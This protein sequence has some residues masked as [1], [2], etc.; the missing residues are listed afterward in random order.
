MNRYRTIPIQDLLVGHYVVGIDKSWLDT[1]F[2]SHRFLINS[3]QEIDRLRSHGVRMVMIDPD[4]SSLTS[5]AAPKTPFEPFPESPLKEVSI[6]SYK[7]AEMLTSLHKY[8]VVKY[9]TLFDEIRHQMEP[10]KKLDLQPFMNALGEVEKLGREYPDAYLFL[11]HLQSTDDETFIHSVNTM[12][13]ALYLAHFRNAS[14]DEAVLWGLSGLFHDMGKARIPLEILH[15]KEPLTAEE[16]SIIREHP[17]TGEQII[18][19]HTSLPSLV[20]KVAGDHHLRRNGGYPDSQ[21]FETTDAVTRAI[22]IF[23]TF[24]ALTSDR[25]YRP[26]ISPSK[27]LRKIIDASKDSLDPD[28]ATQ[29]FLS[30]GVYPVGTVLGLNEG[31]IGVVTKYH[32]RHDT[33]DNN[34]KTEQHFSVLILKTHD[35]YPVV[36]PFTRKIV[37][38]PSTPPPVA[39]TYNHSDFMIDW[40]IIRTHA[41]YWM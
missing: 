32:S 34:K 27:A 4:R 36:R 16:W 40:D 9:K 38:S 8:L 11:A 13:L 33:P 10:D 39:K 17:R 3:Q 18:S 30:M 7:V 24:D 22:M 6:P 37:W 41:R 35:G 14:H 15:K 5:S 21:L 29:F 26:G 25:C 20:A 28:W 2:L 12:F 23:D 31:E 19:N 1:P